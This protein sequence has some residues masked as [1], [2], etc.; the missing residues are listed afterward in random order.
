M[1]I[2]EDLDAR[3]VMKLYLNLRSLDVTAV[4]NCTDATTRANQ[5]PVDLFI[6]DAFFSGADGFEVVRQFREAFPETPMILYTGYLR[7][8]ERDKA[9]EAGATDFVRKPNFENLMKSL[10]QWGIFAE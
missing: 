3:T 8:S 1:Y 10:E 2:D 6:I 4:S 7:D 5:E 9:I